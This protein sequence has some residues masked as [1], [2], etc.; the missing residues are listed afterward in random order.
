MTWAFSKNWKIERWW[1]FGRL[2]WIS[3]RRIGNGF[4]QLV[5]S[6]VNYFLSF[7][8]NFVRF[9]EIGVIILHFLELIPHHS[10][11]NSSSFQIIESIIFAV[12]CR[13]LFGH[14]FEGI[15]QPHY[16]RVLCFSCIF[17]ILT[18]VGRKHSGKM[19]E[20]SK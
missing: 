19:K 18:N 20:R 6:S 11:K 8:D 1:N 14:C 12:P 3:I 17:C 4:L 5:L 10:E 7:A 13:L 2:W 16:L 9:S 15:I